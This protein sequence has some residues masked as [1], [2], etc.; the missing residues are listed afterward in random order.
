[1]I[2]DVELL[3]RYVEER[4]ESAF[5]ELVRR[6]VDLVY[7]VALR[8]VGGDAHLAQDVT[9]RV[10]VDLARKAPAL[11][12]RAVLSGWL[13]RSA[14]YAGSDAVRGERRRRAREEESQAMQETSWVPAE[15][16][17][18]N[19]VRPLLDEAL[20]EL[21]EL[22]RDAIALRY[23]ENR[24]F[25]EIGTRLRLNE[26]AARKRVER[27]LDKL[28]ATLS[29]HGVT[30]STAAL[31]VALASHVSVAA[32]AGLAGSVTAAS[33]AAGAAASSVGVGTFLGL[34]LA[35]KIGFGVVGM[36]TTVAI[37]VAW[38]EARAARES[39]A[40]LVATN[41][42]QDALRTQVHALRT[43]LAAANRRAQAAEDDSAQLLSAIA[44]AS[45]GTGTAGVRESAAQAAIEARYRRAQEFARDGKWDTALTELL[46]CFD[47]G[48]ANN[49]SFSG[50][51][52]SVLLS[53]IAKLAAHHPPAA[54]A[55]RERRDRAQA[56]L[57]AE[58]T[59]GG[60]A[61]EFTS[62][63][64]AL[65]ESQRTLEVYDRLPADDPRRRRLVL[66]G[67]YQ[68][69]VDVRRY[70]DAMQAVP[71]ERMVP[72][73]ERES[74]PPNVTNEQYPEMALKRHRRIVV[75]DAAKNVEVLAGAGDLVHAREFAARVLA[76][77]GSS[78][79]R[80]LL[81]R[82]AARAGQPALLDDG[83]D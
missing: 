17:D 39:Q 61:H 32:P 58:Q 45:A 37:G 15:N 80:E 27:A 64:R 71:F 72:W 74:R 10:F 23:F 30:S 9:Q 65:G 36:A 14:Q 54:T 56:R 59:D 21:N 25:A 63:N 78:E 52:L 7:S 51:R 75:G 13:C 69:L 22:D 41:R 4:S 82:H 57:L 55:L 1:M 66:A 53:D 16:V 49:S 60:A 43:E 6:R 76:F 20:G 33:L 79:T 18:W 62:I 35:G 5:A 19:R 67:T 11:A 73:F 29:R 50:T 24:P 77:D 28:G 31:G 2:E 12:Q 83:Q 70:P 38:Q 3:R 26:E 42:Q 68:L 44:R 81:Q 34:S 46:W 47:E 8:K 40:A 48:M